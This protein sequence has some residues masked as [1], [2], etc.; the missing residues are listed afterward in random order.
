M[1]GKIEVTSERKVLWKN[2]CMIGEDCRECIIEM[3][4]NKL[5]FFIIGLELATGEYHLVEM[6]RAQANNVIKACDNN[7]QKLMTFLEFRFGKMQI[8]DYDMLLQ[9][10]LY[11]P[12]KKRSD[13]TT[14]PSVERGDALARSRNSVD[15]SKM[16]K[17]YK[18][19]LVDYKKR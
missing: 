9:H 13:L 19:K 15:A 3:S 14:L 2:V 8:K 18:P 10:Q 5:K 1:T 6:W 11:Q 17:N 12:T 4:R 16:S 7:L